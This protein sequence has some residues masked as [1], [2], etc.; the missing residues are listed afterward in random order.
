M[1]RTRLRLLLAVIAALPLSL[2]GP[3]QEARSQ[4]RASLPDVGRVLLVDDFETYGAGSYPGSGGWGPLYGA[5]TWTQEIDRS[6][7]AS[8]QSELILPGPRA[9]P[10][11]LP[12][13]PLSLKQP[14]SVR[15]GTAPVVA[16]AGMREAGLRT[17]LPAVPTHAEIVRRARE[18]WPNDPSHEIWQYMEDGNGS[19]GGTEYPLSREG[20][21]NN[22]NTADPDEDSV[23]EGAVREDRFTLL[24]FEHLPSKHEII[25]W[26]EHFWDPRAG[27]SSDGLSVVLWVCEE[28]PFGLPPFA[29]AVGSDTNAYERAQ[30]FWDEARRLYAEPGGAKKAEAYYYLG[31]VAH[32]L[33]DMGTP[34][35]VSMD[36]HHIPAGLC[37][38]IP[39]WLEA[40][41]TTGDRYEEYME[42]ATPAQ[43][44]AWTQAA[45]AHAPFIMDWDEL[46]I[47]LAGRAIAFDSNDKDGTLDRGTRREGGFSEAERQYIAD[48][49]MPWTIGYTAAL[50]RAFWK[51][52]GNGV[53]CAWLD[54]DPTEGIAP[55]SVSFAGTRSRSTFASI[56]S[57][58]WDFGDNQ[59]GSGATVDHTFTDAGAYTV[60]LTV[61]D[62][63]GHSDTAEQVIVVQPGATT[64]SITYPPNGRTVS[65]T[66]TIKV[67]AEP[68]ANMT[69]GKVEFTVDWCP[70]AED[71]EAPYECP[72][73][74]SEY[75]GNRELRAH[76]LDRFNRWTH[77]D[78]VLVNVDHRIMRLR[79]GEVNPSKG[80]TNT[81]FQFWVDYRHAEGTAPIAKRVYV[82]STAYDMDLEN[83]SS[84]DFTEYLT[85][86]ATIAGATLGAGAHEFYFEFS[87]G[88]NTARF[89]SSGTVPGPMVGSQPPIIYFIEPDGD[90]DVADTSYTIEWTATDPDNDDASL[91]VDLWWDTDRQEPLP[92]KTLIAA[93][94]PNTGSYDW[95]TSRM[96]L[97]PYYIFGRVTDGEGGEDTAYSPGQVTIQ[98]PERPCTKVWL[99]P[100]TISSSGSNQL[101]VAVGPANNVHL[102]WQEN[103]RV[104]YRHSSD[105]GL[106]W[107]ASRQLSDGQGKRPRIAVDGQGYAHV[108][109]EPP[110]GTTILYEK[111]NSSG[112]SVRHNVPLPSTP[113]YSERPDIAVDPNGR[114]H[115]VWLENT[116]PR[117]VRYS[118]SLDGGQ[119]WPSHQQVASPT[120]RKRPGITA[121]ATDVFVV[122]QYDDPAPSQDEIYFVRGSG[123]GSS[124]SAPVKISQGEDDRHPEIEAD[125]SGQLHVVWDRR[126][127]IVYRR[128]GDL[129]SSW[130]TEKFLTSS[131]DN[132]F[133]ELSCGLGSVY[134]AYE[135]IGGAVG[136]AIGFRESLDGGDTWSQECPFLGGLAEPPGLAVGPD[137]VHLAYK[138]WSM[139][140]CRT[141]P[142][143]MAP[144]ITVT[145]PDEPAELADSSFSI[146]WTATD[147]D[148]DDAL[149]AIDLYYDDD[150]DA[151]QKQVIDQDLPNTP[152]YQWDTST[153]P[154]GTYYVCAVATDPGG[155]FGAA[156]AVGTVQINHPATITVGQPD[157]TDDIADD[158]YTIEWTASDPDADVLTIDLYYDVDTDATDK[159]LI[160]QGVANTGSY[161]WDTSA[162]SAGQY[163]V[164]AIA[165]DGWHETAAYSP[166][167]VQVNHAPVVF[168]TT[169][170]GEE[171]W[172][173]TRR[174]TWAA[175]DPDG[176]TVQ[177]ML[178]HSADNGATWLSLAGPM[179]N[180]GEY[181]WDTTTVGDGTQYLVRVAASDGTAEGRDQSQSPFCI[182][183]AP[184]ASYQLPTT[185]YH[186]IS[187]PLTP[188]LITVHDVLCDDLGDG[189]FYMWRWSGHGYESIPTSLPESQATTLGLREGYWI[190]AVA[191]SIDMQGLHPITDQRIPLQPGWNLIAARLEATMD[192]LLVDNAGDVRT[193]AE[194]Q[195]A[196]WAAATFYYSLDT[197]TGAYG[198]ITIGQAPEDRVSLWHGY[199]VLAGLECFLI[200]P[201]TPPSGP[202]SGRTVV[203]AVA[204]LAWAFEIE[205]K[206]GDTTDT[207][208]IAAASGASAGFDGYALDMAKPPAPPESTRLRMVLE[209]QGADAGGSLAPACELAMETKDA[210]EDETEWAFVVTSGVEGQPVTLTWPDLSQ[211]P[212]DRVA[213]LTDRDAGKRSFMRSRAQYEFAAPGDGASRSFTVTV[214][215]AQAGALLISGLT[216]GP[217]RGGAWDIGFNLSADAAVTGRVYNVA[218]RRVADIAQA[219]QLARGRASLVWDSRSIANTHV[220]SGVY[221]LR[222]TARTEEGEQASAVRM[223][224]VRR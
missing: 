135:R 35:H 218:G 164:Y 1:R 115:V 6:R 222:V 126:D 48:E 156:Y 193:L 5:T 223:L 76:A 146:E 31:R 219:Q 94:L 55:L 187:L 175:D 114:I 195:D 177:V 176:D 162:M 217:T 71:S 26:L 124:W 194:A 147:P 140:Y 128:S 29:V 157:G 200:I 17:R 154:G 84:P 85:F 143:G 170:T 145:N 161:V 51:A 163:Y 192:S 169:P 78:P 39:D 43:Y 149:V 137:A 92:D 203:D 103:S 99:T 41:Y 53:I 13:T 81:D 32:L 221:L 68:S 75:T 67:D 69:G 93:D 183:N 181:D 56:V 199:W 125:P 4:A 25:P 38:W 205:A 23:L 15:P 95:E 180:T 104:R 80:E 60:K 214:K 206:S 73:D 131:G 105:G 98:G 37:E 116:S 83:P 61:T 22:P 166:G 153:V 204:P 159:T 141:V 87:D 129:G 168:L 49:L 14:A 59:T 54:A 89:P 208:T 182:H 63:Q 107:A 106:S 100:V 16:A 122:Y 209:A 74:T 36:Q 112:E 27:P 97:R 11:R 188:S 123:S 33:A 186:M 86:E 118:R 216:T 151:S 127:N 34:A 111:I 65:G 64:V 90:N 119:T 167:V 160:E 50:F 102:V 174:V 109:W 133:A 190:L 172:S 30:G 138:G 58:E 220:P 198:T 113:D 178:Q 96:P 185:G 121:T 202:T 212:K 62:S 42:N 8:A 152:P 7:A 142:P 132:R 155:L 40:D 130:T 171:L 18:V 72:W 9:A 24:D 46:F 179:A 158:S 224:Q 21:L 150:Q 110:A 79:S 2:S 70:I 77:S 91:R 82:D 45:H 184:D 12:L 136:D 207:I 101:A 148:G 134:V 211:L 10:L 197:G 20:P 120:E 189:A 196:E 213:I 19:N 139:L 108:V 28:P 3:N 117:G 47:G 66:I 210:A 191:A 57:W 44:G 88:T 173:G 215:P 52:V 144:Q 165:K 201:V